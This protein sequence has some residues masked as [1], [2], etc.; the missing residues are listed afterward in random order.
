M[1]VLFSLTL[2]AAGM[3]GL[4]ALSVRAAP[5][6]PAVQLDGGCVVYL[7]AV[8]SHGVGCHI[9]YTEPNDAGGE[10]ELIAA[11]ACDQRIQVCGELVRCE[12]PE[13]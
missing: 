10:T 1:R 2:L 3:L 5:G 9:H 12:C 13:K 6:D 7:E 4:A 8:P 11:V